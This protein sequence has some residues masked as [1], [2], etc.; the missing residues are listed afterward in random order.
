MSLVWTLPCQVADDLLAAQLSS[1]VWRR[2]IHSALNLHVSDTQYYLQRVHKLG[3]LLSDEEINWRSKCLQ[4]EHRT[5]NS[6]LPAIKKV[7]VNS[8]ASF[9]LSLSLARTILT[10][11]VALIG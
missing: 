4:K 3:T 8:L 7:D 1:E 9:P 11:R 2:L 5:L 6:S 10:P